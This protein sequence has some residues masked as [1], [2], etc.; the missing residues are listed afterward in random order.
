MVTNRSNNSNKE[1]LASL[2]SSNNSFEENEPD[3]VYVE[4]LSLV[5][6]N[7]TRHYGT[8]IENSKNSIFSLGKTKYVR[9]ELLYQIDNLIKDSRIK[10]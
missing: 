7:L 1:P 2:R 4:Q 5:K 10:S 6:L 9:I 8:E 3:Y